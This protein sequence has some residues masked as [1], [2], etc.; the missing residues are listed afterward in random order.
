MRAAVRTGLLGMTIA[1]KDDVPF[2][3][4]RDPNVPIAPT[5]VLVSGIVERVGS[6]VA[7]LKIGD[8]VFGRCPVI[9]GKGGSLAEYA[10]VPMDEIAIKPEWL[11]FDQAAALGVA[12][13][14][15]LQSLR[16]GNVAGDSS[17]L[18]IGASGGCGIAG[19]QLARAMGVSRI[20]GICSGMDLELIDYTNQ[21]SMDKFKADNVV[22]F[23]CIY[24]TATGS[25]NGEDYVASMMPLLRGS[26]GTY[27]QINGSPTTMARHAIGRMKAQRKVVFV[28]EKGRK[29]LE[30]IVSLLKIFVARPHLDVKAFDENGVKGAFE[31]LRGRRT[32]GKIVFNI[33]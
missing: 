4:P 28:S 21:D 32:K 31:Q 25:G 9:G 2:P 1:L 8:A 6:D 26:T 13:L 19:V 27:V 7:D 10:L 17:V 29:D 5:D 14:T 3:A 18:I 16:A 23:D 20:V 30:E 22:M 15:G 11:N 24:D 33:S 12:Y